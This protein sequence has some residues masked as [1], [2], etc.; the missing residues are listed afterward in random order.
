MFEHLGSRKESPR[1]SEMDKDFKTDAG[2]LTGKGEK[3]AQGEEKAG[4][5]DNEMTD[6]TGDKQ[7]AQKPRSQPTKRDGNRKNGLDTEAELHGNKN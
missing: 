2:I 6:A 7:R 3:W 4:G 1:E 5:P